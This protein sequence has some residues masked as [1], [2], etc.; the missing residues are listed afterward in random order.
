M[1]RLHRQTHNR[2]WAAIRQRVLDRDGHRCKDRGL[3]MD[4]V[5]RILIELSAGGD[6]DMGNLARRCARGCHIAGKA[7]RSPNLPGRV[8]PG[9]KEL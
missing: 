1:S 5:K 3:E 8:A 9:I 4:A 7:I 2:V 6:N